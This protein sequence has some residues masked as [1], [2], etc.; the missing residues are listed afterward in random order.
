[1]LNRIQYWYRISKAYLLPTTSQLS[2][3]HGDPESNLSNNLDKFGKY[4][5]KFHYKADYSGHFDVNDIPML[6]YH[7]KIGIQYNPIAIAQYGLGNYNLFLDNNNNTRLKKFITVSDWLVENLEPNRYG[8]S[9]WHHNFD[10]E[11]CEKLKSPWYSGLAQGMGLSVLL[12]AYN[13]TSDNKYLDAHNLAW[14]S[15]TKDINQGG[16]IYIDSIGNKWIEEYIVSSPTHILNGFIWALWG[17]YDT[18]KVLGT[19]DAKELFK[20]CLNTIEYNLLQYDTNYWSLYELSGT[21]IPMV[22]SPFYHKL[23]IVQLRILYQL[24]NKSIFIDTANKWEEYL[25][26]RSKKTKAF[27]Q[28]IL[29][30]IF[31]Y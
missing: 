16:V 24:T 19:N 12:R 2:F 13:E 4:Y 31:Y 10:F 28:K 29:F 15:F 3:W 21:H 6:N 14:E 30:K 7:G 27:L 20:E 5:M 1:L 17:V 9:V 26:S 23:H 8:I 22:S 25:F 11:Y 18:W